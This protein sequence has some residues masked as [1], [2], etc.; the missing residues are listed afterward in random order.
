MMFASTVGGG[1]MTLV[2]R[3]AKPEKDAVVS[4]IKVPLPERVADTGTRTSGVTKIG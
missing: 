1:A 2:F 4:A 3:P